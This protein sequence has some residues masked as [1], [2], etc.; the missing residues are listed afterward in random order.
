MPETGDNISNAEMLLYPHSQHNTLSGSAR[1]QAHIHG[2]GL[3]GSIATK[4]GVGGQSAKV[5]M[6]GRSEEG[7]DGVGVGG[8]DAFRAAGEGMQE[9]W[10][11]R[12]R[13][14]PLS[15]SVLHLAV[16]SRALLCT[17]F[18][19]MESTAIIGKMQASLLVVIVVVLVIVVS[20][21]V[22]EVVVLIGNVCWGER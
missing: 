9:R 19:L 1:G 12:G 11:R 10:E 7:E 2:A 17:I 5:G 13:F 3:D 20:V 8:S 21:V 22:A 18:W 6:E 4:G 16:P 14:F 15:L